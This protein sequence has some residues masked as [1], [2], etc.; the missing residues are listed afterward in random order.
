MKDAFK[1]QPAMSGSLSVTWDAT[2][3]FAAAA[4][5]AYVSEQM[6]ALSLAV[7]VIC[8]GMTA[9]HA[10]RATSAIAHALPD[11]SPA[12]PGRWVRAWLLPAEEPRPGQVQ[13]LD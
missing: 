4:G 5:S 13:K 12:A 8:S 9:L 6:T 2:I 3:A 7:S 1:E 10:Y 11:D